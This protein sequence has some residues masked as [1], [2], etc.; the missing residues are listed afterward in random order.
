MRGLAATTASLARMRQQWEQMAAR[1][2]RLPGAGPATPAVPSRLSPV[3][4]FG[5][6]PGALEMFTYVPDHLPPAP[7]LVVVLH[8][9]TQSAAAYDHGS[10]WSDLADRHGFV[11]VYPQQNAANNQKTCFNWFVPG[12][13][14]R[15]RGEAL[16]IRQMVERASRDHGIDPARIFVTGLSAGGAM[17]AVMLATYPELFAGGAVV[18]GLPYGAALNVQQAL[19]SMFQGRS[20]PGSRLG[21]LVRAASPHR[22]PWP[23]L[24]VWHGSAD[25]V[26][27]PGNAEELVK[28]WSNLH[29]LPEEPSARDIVDG[30]SRRT[31]R[32]AG[33]RAVMEAFAI[34]GM[35]HGTPLATGAGEGKAGHAGPYMLEAGIS[36]TDHIAAFWGLTETRMPATDGIAVVS[37]DGTIRLDAKRPAAK[38]RVEPRVEPPSRAATL[39]VNAIIARA[40]RAAGLNRP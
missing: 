21:D 10:G 11:L 14:A 36:S 8:G 31:W 15:D 38:T 18:A 4:E 32:D 25:A 22:G 23:R 27:K 33:G 26:V 39:D 35:G 1:A 12:D 6:N 24:S 9:C 2:S 37:P 7:A 3:S 5:T 19:E 17:T 16:S 34:A 29:G 28:Q 30:Q 20:L 13:I 40:F